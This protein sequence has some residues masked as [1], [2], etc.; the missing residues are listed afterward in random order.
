MDTPRV[1][2]Q[3]EHRVLADALADTSRARGTARL[4]RLFRALQGRNYRLYVAGQSVSLLGTWMQR[5]ALSWWVYQHTHSALALGLVGGVGQLPALF[6]APLAGALVDRW[7]RQR[8]LVV[9]QLLAMLQALGLAWLVLAGRATLWHVLLC[10]VLLGMINAVDMPARQALVGEFVKQPADL[11]N[12][13]ALNASITNGAR[14]IGP[15]LAG[16]VIMRL[17]EGICFLLNG[18]SYLAL[19]AAVRAMRLPPRPTASHRT[20]LLAEAHAGVRYAWSCTPVRAMLVL[21]TVANLLG[22]PYQ[23]LLPVFATDVLHGDAHTLARLTAASGV[24]AILGALALA[25]RDRVGGVGRVLVL[26]TSLFGLG[27]VGLSYTRRESVAWLTLIAAS[28]GMM[29]LS[30]TS[31]TAVQTLVEEEKR[32]RILSLY[33]MVF[34]G[35]APVGSLVAGTVATHLTAPHMVRIGGLCCLAG[36]LVF[37]RYLSALRALVRPHAATSS[38]DTRAGRRPV[39]C[40]TSMCAVPAHVHALGKEQAQC[41]SSK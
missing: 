35:T 20:P 5:L 19:L 8:L 13:L 39:N 18:L 6:L 12:A 34:L 11:S 23:V 30:T 38:L 16:L 32:G 26:S 33:S 40:E 15:A 10:S 2:E 27:L 7:D 17:G 21:L 3:E 29:G 24:G 14:L 25:S 37:A 41:G 1:S 22:M 4:W 31:Q 28:G 9:T 36:A